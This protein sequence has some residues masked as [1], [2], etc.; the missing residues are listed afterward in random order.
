M[1]EL[2]EFVQKCI[3][4]QESLRKAL[5]RSGPKTKQS[6]L[7][8][9][10]LHKSNISNDDICDA[11]IK[12]AMAGIEDL[13]L[14]AFEDV[15][16]M[17]SKV[18]KE[19]DI[20]SYSDEKQDDDDNDQDDDADC[21]SDSPLKQVNIEGKNSKSSKTTR[22]DQSNLRSSTNKVNEKTLLH[23]LKIKSTS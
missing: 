4:T 2:H 13:P 12:K 5:G 11:L 8:E 18:K 19:V 22:Q 15:K 23:S 21:D 7:W 14:K 16:P 17:V 10:K 6:K 1:E 3:R 20:K 9:E